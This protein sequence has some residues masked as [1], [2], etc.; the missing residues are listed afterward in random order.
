MS[1]ISNSRDVSDFRSH[2]RTVLVNSGAKPLLYRASRSNL[3]CSLCGLMRFIRS[4]LFGL[5]QTDPFTLASSALPLLAIAMLAG[6]DPAR[7]AS[8]IQPIQVLR[9]Q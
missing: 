3:R 8:L 5:N 2:F 9:R 6:W 1:Q 4:M 7:R